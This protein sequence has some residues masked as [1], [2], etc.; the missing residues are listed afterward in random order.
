ML[1]V[2]LAT[3]AIKSTHSHRPLQVGNQ[4]AL[5]QALVID[6]PSFLAAYLGINRWGYAN[7]SLKRLTDTQSNTYGPPLPRLPEGRPIEILPCTG[8]LHPTSNSYTLHARLSRQGSH[9]KTLGRGKSAVPPNLPGARG[10][11]ERG[12]VAAFH[13]QPL[14]RLWGQDGLSLGCSFGAVHAGQRNK[15]A[16]LRRDGRYRAEVHGARPTPNACTRFC[17]ARRCSQSIPPTEF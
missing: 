15:A 8:R 2:R 16:G 10:L 7:H 12:G 3:S 17:V 6:V 9:R 5:H 4:R 13:Q 11:G 1:D 14:H